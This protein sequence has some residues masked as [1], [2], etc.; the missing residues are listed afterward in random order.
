MNRIKKS[1]LFL[2]AFLV[3]SSANIACYAADK[4]QVDQLQA[5]MKT[6]SK[7]VR[8]YV[9]C[10]KGKCTQEEKKAARKA[11]LKDG[12]I[13]AAS[14]AAVA[15]VG[16]AGYF[17]WRWTK[18]RELERAEKKEFLQIAFDKEEAFAESFPCLDR[19]SIKYI[20]PSF[21]RMFPSTTYDGYIN[22]N[23]SETPSNI[24]EIVQKIFSQDENVSFS[25]LNKFLF[26]YRRK[27]MILFSKFLSDQDK[28]TLKD[29]FNYT[30]PFDH[31]IEIEEKTE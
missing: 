3:A 17:G 22:V 25:V 23:L 26:D 31:I 9:R 29:K 13:L 10:V 27:W 6:F 14:I 1:S 4:N 16:T 19:A 7:R 2:L 18:K 20:G 24:P 8:V 5:Q 15:G 30:E 11:A 28:S 21:G 12:V